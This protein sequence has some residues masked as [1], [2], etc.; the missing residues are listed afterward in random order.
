MW[1]DSDSQ[2]VLEVAVRIYFVQEAMGHGFPS[3]ISD[4]QS[5]LP[6]PSGCFKRRYA[7]SETGHLIMRLVEF[8]G[9]ISDAELDACASRHGL[10][11]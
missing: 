11:C 6:F 8:V 7:V 5:A 2:R 4:R 10:F 3:Y 1:M 9:D